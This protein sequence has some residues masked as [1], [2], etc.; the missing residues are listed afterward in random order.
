[1]PKPTN[2]IPAI[3][4]GKARR[5]EEINLDDVE[6]D[7]LELDEFSQGIYIG[8][9]GDLVVTLERDDD[10]VTFV[11]IGAGL[12]HAIKAKRIHT[13]TTAGDIVVVY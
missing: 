9:G 8:S 7:Y 13:S 11:G 1:M 12:T 4:G 10:S 2:A 5:A 3:Q 6:G